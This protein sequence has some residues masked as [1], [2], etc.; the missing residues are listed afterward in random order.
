MLWIL[1]ITLHGLMALIAIAHLALLTKRP[2]VQATWIMS[3]VFLPLLGILAY[4]FFGTD[5]M[6]LARLR[7]REAG[8]YRDR[9]EFAP[10][11]KQLL[12][13]DDLPWNNCARGLSQLNRLQ[14]TIGNRVAVLPDA[15]TCYPKLESA[16]KKATKQIWIQFYVW[17]PDA[18]GRHFLDL[19]I[20]A[21]RRG[22]AVRLLVDEIGSGK[23]FEHFFRDLIAAGGHFSWTM[24]LHPRRNRW[25]VNLR[26]H[27]KIVIIDG[28]L[29]FTGGLNIGDEY[30][31]GFRGHTW[32]DL[33]VQVQ[34]PAVRQLAAIFAE[35]WYF[36][37]ETRLSLVTGT[38]Q[39]DGSLIQVIA[40]GPDRQP[41]ITAL[42][43]LTILQAARER[44]I[45]S[46]PFLAPDEH[47]LET[48]EIAVARGVRVDLLVSAETDMG[49]M[50]STGHAF[51]PRLLNAGVHVWEYRDD[52]HHAKLALIDSDWTLVGSINLDYRSFHLNHEVALFIRSSEVTK[53]VEKMLD[54]Y[55]QGALEWDWDRYRNRPLWLRLMEGMLRLLAPLL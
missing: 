24:T 55:R 10:D 12:T 41:S 1:L 26:N 38:N 39:P 49:L 32:H 22:V 14:A 46:T 15:S 31:D 4:W 21:C 43:M 23:T 17:R 44:I 29:A 11:P 18:T 9:D 6:L 45:L 35:D 37:T 13:E 36:A 28:G 3:I 54:H 47:F 34:G 50:A 42:S 40:G 53:Q 19:L 16:L 5:R 52:I 20:D 30:V 8:Q 7:R 27:R 33:H 51:F 25:F 2:V 48:I